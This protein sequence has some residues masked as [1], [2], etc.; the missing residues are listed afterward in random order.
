MVV[1][2]A[3]V[4]IGCGE[5]ITD[6]PLHALALDEEKAIVFKCDLCGGDP[7]CVKW[8]TMGALTLKEVSLDSSDRQAFVDKVSKYLH[9]VGS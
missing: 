9:A 1:L 4:C 7:E 2:D 8:C 3:E 6:C 5:C